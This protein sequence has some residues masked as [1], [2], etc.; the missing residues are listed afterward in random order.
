MTSLGRVGR[1]LAGTV[2]VSNS[3]F[4]KDGQSLNNV[5]NSGSNSS[6]I[7]LSKVPDSADLRDLDK[8]SNASI[9]S[10]QGM[11]GMYIYLL[12]SFFPE[13]LFYTKTFFLL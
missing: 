4:E 13:R 7:T 5:K 6:H 2:D 8:R 9:S 10:M 1:I 12:H 11:Q 3:S